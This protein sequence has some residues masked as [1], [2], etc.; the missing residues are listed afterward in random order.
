MR[1][2]KVIRR[3]AKKAGETELPRRFNFHWNPPFILPYDY[4]IELVNEALEYVIADVE[5]RR[6]S[7]KTLSLEVDGVE[8]DGDTEENDSDT[9]DPLENDE[10]TIGESITVS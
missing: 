1:E 4:D 5:K 3:K 7:R 6:A 9:T 2:S 8:I 10:I